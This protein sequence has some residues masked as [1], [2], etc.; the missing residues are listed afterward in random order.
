G[1]WL[2]LYSYPEMATQYGANGFLSGFEQGCYFH[3]TQKICECGG[4]NAY[5][6]FFDGK[7]FKTYQLP[8]CDGP[9]GTIELNA[10]ENFSGTVIGTSPDGDP[11]T[12]TYS[13]VP[14]GAN[15][16]PANGTV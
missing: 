9:S 14:S 13:G 8:V 3:G 1:F 5:F 16:D 12:V 15:I 11:L 7:H 2:H 10:G 6:G 4:S